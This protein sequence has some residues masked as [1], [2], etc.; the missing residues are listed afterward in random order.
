MELLD[1]F[2]R[3]LASIYCLYEKNRDFPNSLLQQFNFHT[4][5]KDAATQV[6]TNDEESESEEEPQP[7]K[8]DK[9]E[10]EP[11]PQHQKKKIRSKVRAMI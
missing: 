4:A 11:Q 1:A 6:A 2:W 9:E 7:T 8:E 3:P 5:E 10:Y